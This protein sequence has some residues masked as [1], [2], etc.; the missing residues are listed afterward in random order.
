VNSHDSDSKE[1]GKG[2]MFEALREAIRYVF[3]EKRLH[4]IMANYMPSNVR[5]ANLLK[6]LGFVEEGYAKEYLLINGRWED[7]ILTALTNRGWEQA[8]NQ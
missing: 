4:R 1:E 7:H 8:K 3:V 2:L 5:S 6:K